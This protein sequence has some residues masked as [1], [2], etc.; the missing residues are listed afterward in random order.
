MPHLLKYFCNFVLLLKF[1]EFLIC[2]QM[3]FIFNQA[4]HKSRYLMSLKLMMQ[5]KLDVTRW[6]YKVS[7]HKTITLNRHDLD[8]RFELA[9]QI[10]LHDSMPSQWSRCILT[11]L[12]IEGRVANE[13]LDI[14]VA[15]SIE[16]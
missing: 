6:H 15:D 11:T 12:V 14:D 8:R 9:C 5:N 7:I 4:V 2:L 10:D 16:Q 13:T 3:T 1:K